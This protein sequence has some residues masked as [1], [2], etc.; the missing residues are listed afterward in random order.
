[1][2]TLTTARRSLLAHLA[3]GATLDYVGWGQ[4][5]VLAKD[6]YD[7]VSIVHCQTLHWAQRRGFVYGREIT[8]AGRAA[9]AAEP[10]P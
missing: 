3:A 1:M 6:T 9:L 4:Y 10:A 5:R 7:H 8:P 2:S